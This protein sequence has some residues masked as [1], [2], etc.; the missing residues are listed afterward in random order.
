MK[1]F[2]LIAVLLSAAIISGC[3]LNQVAQVATTDNSEKTPRTL[4]FSEMYELENNG[5]TVIDY[6]KIIPPHIEQTVENFKSCKVILPTI[7]HAELS[8]L[9]NNNPTLLKNIKFYWDG[10]CDNGI[11][12]GLGR[13]VAKGD[14]YHSESITVLSGNNSD[15]NAKFVTFDFVTDSILSVIPNGKFPKAYIV[16][17]NISHQ[18]YLN[19]TK[20]AVSVDEKGVKRGNIYQLLNMSSAFI[21]VDDNVAYRRSDLRND[22]TNNDN[23]AF[24]GEIL[25]PSTGQT[26]LKKITTNDGKYIALLQNQKGDQEE[27]VYVNDTYDNM[28]SKK[29]NEAIHIQL[30]VNAKDRELLLFRKAYLHKYCSQNTSLKTFGISGE[31]ICSFGNKYQN[32][33]AN[34][35]AYLIE[36]TEI[37]AQ[38]AKN[39]NQQKLLSERLEKQRKLEQEIKN[40]QGSSFSFLDFLELFIDIMWYVVK[41]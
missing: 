28:V 36:Q 7:Y 32:E 9:Q 19:V 21:W 18:P 33:Y 11:A 26:K 37:A 25:N 5:N 41:F 22:P 24:V 27:P 31:N 40:R 39:I 6:D 3:K 4:S 8:I 1:K 15:E 2:C 30:E 20:I 38:N 12:K 10:G 35:I 34:T 29:I 16:R 14:Y 13:L 23:V 17:E